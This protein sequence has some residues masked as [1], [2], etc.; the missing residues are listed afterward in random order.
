MSPPAH[1]CEVTL[2]HVLKK[3]GKTGLRQSLADA[4]V[5]RCRLQTLESVLEAAASMS[6]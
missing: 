2:L 5:C 4:E 1:S 6:L 3:E